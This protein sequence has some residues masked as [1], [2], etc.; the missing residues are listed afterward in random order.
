MVEANKSKKKYTVDGRTKLAP[1]VLFSFLLIF[2]NGKSNQAQAKVPQK[3]SVMVNRKFLAQKLW[4]IF[5]LPGLERPPISE[6]LKKIYRIA[7]Q[8]SIFIILSHPNEFG[9]P[10]SRYRA[11]TYSSSDIKTNPFIDIPLDL[12]FVDGC[13]KNY[14]ERSPAPFLVSNTLFRE[15]YYEQVCKRLTFPPATEKPNSVWIAN[16][17]NAADLN[18]TSQISSN[19][20]SKAYD[21]FFPGMPISKK[22]LDSL[23]AVSLEKDGGSNVERW[24]LIIYGLCRGSDELQF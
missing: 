23:R 15:A 10:C 2:S 12:D 5:F 22:T 17:L 3:S 16:A 6:A 13:P 7:F 14:D 21:L 4:N 19:S 18:P 9:G 8:E 11:E 20:I 1:L 24:R